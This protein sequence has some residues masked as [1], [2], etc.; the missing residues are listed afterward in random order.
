VALRASSAGAL[1]GSGLEPTPERVVAGL[2]GYGGALIIGDGEIIVGE[3]NNNLR[4]GMVYVYRR[5]GGAW[6]EAAALTAPDARVGDGF[7]ATLAMSGATLYVGSRGGPVHVFRKTGTTWRAAETLAGPE[8]APPG[9]GVAIAASG[10]W[11]LVGAPGSAAGGRGRGAGPGIPGAVF[12]YRRGTGGQWS[13]PQRLAAPDSLAA[14][15]FFGIAIGIAE[16]R[17]LIGASGTSERAGMVHSFRLDSA[18]GQWT[19]TGSLQARGLQATEAFGSSIVIQDDVAAIG[20]PAHG[21]GYGAV[22]FFRRAPESESWLEQSRLVAFNGGRQDRF[23]SA[24]AADGGEMWV[25]VPN[26][27]GTGAAYSF[28]GPGLATAPMVGGGRGGRGGGPSVSAPF[29]S[30]RMLTGSEMETRAAFGATVALR[31]N[32]AAVGAIGQGAD[33]GAGIVLV[34]ERA[35]GGEW[36][37]AATLISAPEALPAL[38]GSERKCSEEG[39][40][41]VFTCGEA[42]LLSF[43]PVKDITIDGRG[44]RLNDIWGWIDSTTNREYA[45]VGRIDG[46][47][48][49]DVT[50]P[51]KPIFIGDLPKTGG[52][53]SAIWRDIK[54]YRNH[55]FIVADASQAH[56]MQV[57]DL[58]QL[59]GHRGKP[60]TFKPSAHYTRMNSAHNIVINEESGFAYAVGSSGGGETCGGGLHMIDIRDPKSPK[61]AGCFADAQTGRS[62]TGYSHDA[63]CVN[64]RGPDRRYTGREICLGSNETALSIADVT[65]KANPKAIS[66]A[67]YP[68]VAYAH[69]GWLTDDHRWFYMDDEGD[70]LAGTT[71]RTRTMIWDI[72]DL[73]DPKLAKEYLGETAASDH[74][75]Y[76][77]GN[78]MYQ[79]NYRAGLRIIDIS[80]RLNPVEAGFFDT[81]PYLENRAGFSGSWS[82][83]P[84]FRSGAIAVTSG[85]EGL[86]LVKKRGATTV[87]Q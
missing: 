87:F 52:S 54:V 20:A 58:T 49:V 80:D 46:T 48:F 51:T 31:G 16:G 36:R 68:N 9:F 44:V 37:E 56:G 55:A 42:E 59:R 47:S 3:P 32:L 33:H 22:F 35:A 43:L 62:G 15:A 76:I 74:N 69:Q 41:G 19:S 14:G 24:L 7:G 34:Y 38:V 4:P 84:F 64:Y 23:G 83:Y 82:N 17:A 73:E 65:D 63:Q 77:K 75:L 26:A 25:G 28:R 30:G 45:L 13:Q 81:A 29:A 60:V 53:P 21:G 1:H 78:L 12:A 18:S 50:D 71:S 6:R 39:T 70:E 66:R 10:D 8:S 67:S 79:S 86:F 11:L 2:G 85:N 57:F 72:S 40:V 5:T 61:F 27:A